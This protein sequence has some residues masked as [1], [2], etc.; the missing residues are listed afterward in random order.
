MFRGLGGV[1]ERSA[2]DAGSL[3]SSLSAGSAALN[4]AAAT[5][6]LVVSGVGTPLLSQTSSDG[7]VVATKRQGDALWRIRLLLSFRMPLELRVPSAS[8]GE[9]AQIKH[10]RN[11][12]LVSAS[13]QIVPH[14]LRRGLSGRYEELLGDRL[15]LIATLLPSALHF[16]HNT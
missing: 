5:P 7:D 15:R 12:D 2:A 13:P 6:M 9:L 8:V 16:I 11:K 1:V 3:S 10:M 14:K 4:P